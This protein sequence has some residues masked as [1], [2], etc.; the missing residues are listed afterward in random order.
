MSERPPEKLESERH[1]PTPD[2]LVPVEREA[3]PDDPKVTGVDTS[4]PEDNR[5]AEL[6]QHTIDLPVLASAVE[7]QEAADAADTLETLDEDEAAEVLE[8]MEVESAAAALSQMQIPLAVGVLDDLLLR[9][10]LRYVGDLLDHMAPDDAADLIQAIDDPEKSTRLLDAMTTER[11]AEVV[12]LLSYDEETAGGLMTTDFLAL[13]ND[14]TV[15][16]AIEFIRS[17][18]IDEAV[19]TAMVIDRHDRLMGIMRL[20]RLLLAKPTEQIEDLMDRGVKAVRP[21]VDQEDVAREFD[22]YD[23]EIMPVVDHNNRLLGVITVDDV[24]DIIRAEQTEDT[25]KLVGA[26]AEEAVYSTSWEKFKGRFPWLLV[27][28]F[29]STLAAIVVLQF[30]DLIGE[31]AILAVLMPVIANQAGNAGQ[32][33]LAVTLRGIVLDQ[34]HTDSISSLL[35]REA[36]VGL[37]NGIVGGVLVGIGLTLLS[38]LVSGAGWRLGMVAAIAMSGALMLGCFVGSSMP[39]LMRRAGFDP[40]TGSTIFLTMTTDS[41]SFFAF[42][43]LAQLFSGWLLID[44]AVA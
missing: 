37:I 5:V 15:Q 44:A 34:I 28:L 38:P 3:S 9:E 17:V 4:S 2:P 29:T 40:A 31:L 36:T 32:Q 35:R 6:L 14:E 7:Q 13:H 23:F 42:L 18:E 33:S 10:D 21:D 26:G 19:H 11:A 22:R 16:G 25:Q 39:I 1:D 12:H 41:M 20:R 30:E 8:Q 43:G 27:N 24:I